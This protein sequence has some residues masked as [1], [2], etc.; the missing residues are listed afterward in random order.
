MSK[1]FTIASSR[2]M[3]LPLR[4]GQN[5]RDD[6]S[7]ALKIEQILA[8]IHEILF[9]LKNQVLVTDQKIKYFDWDWDFKLASTRST[10]QIQ[11]KGQQ[12]QKS[13]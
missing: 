7:Y 12:G 4:F 9:I 5:D 8:W 10:I 1:L 11:N 3:N 2:S 13:K 6:Q